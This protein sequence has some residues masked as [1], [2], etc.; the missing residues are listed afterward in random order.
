MAPRSEQ[1]AGGLSGGGEPRDHAPDRVLVT[2]LPA[3]HDEVENVSNKDSGRMITLNVIVGTLG[4]I[5][6]GLV[7][8]VTAVTRILRYPFCSPTTYTPEKPCVCTQ[9]RARPPSKKW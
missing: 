8:T 6:C 5:T 3:R 1:S 2:V 7:T 4:H 9:H